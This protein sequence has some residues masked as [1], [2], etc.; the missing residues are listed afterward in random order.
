MKV[1]LAG[2]SGVVGSHLI[3]QLIARGH[4]VVA[5]TTRP[6]RAAAVEAA[7]AQAVVVDL[8][9]GEAV[10]AAVQAAEPEVVVHQATALS[11]PVSL[12]RFDAAFALTNRLR[13]EGL[14]NLLAAAVAAGAPRFVAQSYTGWPNARSGALVKTEADP[15]DPNPPAA[16]RESLAAI[17]KLE[18]AVTG[19]DG[20]AG[21]VLRYG[22]FYGPGTGLGEGGEQVELIRRRKLPLVGS[23]AGVWSFVHIDDAA[24]A[25]VAV[26]E[27]RGGG[28]YNVVD[29]DPAPVA[30]WLPALARALGAKPPRHVPVWLARMLIGEHGIAMMTEMR[31]S[32]NEKA[33]RELGWRPAWPSWR[34]GFEHGLAPAADDPRARAA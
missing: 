5:T 30:E 24:S 32:S 17:R 33:K 27:G 15:L 20:V 26:I 21:V 2:G 12:R 10:A 34:D 18:A 1:F 13:T 3:P 14:D 9:D 6:E 22:S 8:L 19:S 25:T 31:G 23:A 4:E 7:G 11:G 29:D 28:L 16:A